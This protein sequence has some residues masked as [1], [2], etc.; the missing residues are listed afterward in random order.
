MYDCVHTRGN[1]R[2]QA[3]FHGCLS[4]SFG[5]LSVE[6]SWKQAPAIFPSPSSNVGVID[7]CSHAWLLCRYW[8]SELRSSCIHRKSSYPLNCLPIS[9]SFLH[10]C[11]FQPCLT[12]NGGLFNSGLGNKAE[13][14]DCANDKAG[15]KLMPVLPTH[16][17]WGNWRQD[18]GLSP[19]PFQSTVRRGLSRTHLSQR[20]YAVSS[21]SQGFTHTKKGKY[22]LWQKL[23]VLSVSPCYLLAVRLKMTIFYSCC[24]H[25]KKKPLS[26]ILYFILNLSLK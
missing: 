23:Q 12:L 9:Y 11:Q 15:H 24:S 16:E 17:Q 2:T 20:T 6:L 4:Y 14:T 5:I 13:G 25:K 18:L 1:Q 19:S 10:S 21:N 22:S 8:R 7:M 3:V 26:Q